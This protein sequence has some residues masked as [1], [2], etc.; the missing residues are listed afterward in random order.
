MIMDFQTAYRNGRMESME[1]ENDTLGEKMW[2]FAVL[3]FVFLL[4]MW[5]FLVFF[6]TNVGR[7]TVHMFHSICFISKDFKGVFPLRHP[8][9]E[10]EKI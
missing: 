6:E 5:M 9:T 4:I 2:M 7:F 10:T 8:K 3:S 1:S